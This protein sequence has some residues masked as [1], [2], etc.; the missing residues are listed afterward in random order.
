M[1]IQVRARDSV[2]ASN[3]VKDA[4]DC[5]KRGMIVRV[6][7]DGCPWGTKDIMPDFYIVKIPGVPPSHGMEYERERTSDFLS[8]RG[9]RATGGGRARRRDWSILIDELPK[10]VKAKLESNGIIAVPRDLT[11]DAFRACI[12][13]E[14]FGRSER[15]AELRPPPESR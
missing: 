14:R 3:E 15:R 13:S 6:A 10:A 12:W 8:E 1:E 5:Y 4:R 11:W 2:N 7:E 9:R